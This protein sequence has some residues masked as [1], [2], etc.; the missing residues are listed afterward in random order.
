MNQILKLSCA[1]VLVLVA[2][3]CT[4]EGEADTTGTAGPGVGG[5]TTSANGGGS[6]GGGSTGGNSSGGGGAAPMP[7]LADTLAADHFSIARDDLCI[8]AVYDAPALEISGYGTTPTWGSHGGPLTFEADAASATIYRWNLSGS[9]LMATPEDVTLSGLPA[10]AYFGSQVVDPLGVPVFSWTG[11][12]F[13][14]E[15]GV[16]ADDLGTGVS[17]TTIGVTAMASSATSRFLFTALGPMGGTAGDAGVYAGKVL[18]T[19]REASIATDGEV[20]TWGLAT[21]AVAFDGAGNAFAIQTDYVTGTQELRAYASSDVEVGAPAIVG[22]TL[23]TIAG[24]GDALAAV[25]PAGADPGIVL[26]QPNDADT[27]AHLDVTSVEYVKTGAAI[28]VQGTPTPALTLTTADTNLTLM[29]DPSGRVWVG[30]SAT[31]G[32]STF[33]VLRRK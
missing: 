20:D 13:M 6:Q 19:P 2:F 33:Y 10:G 30:G 28:A 32:G 27:S 21:G 7:C 25:T 24:Y 9:T 1:S 18:L 17:T 23:A 22:V 29:T 12:S 11:A 14:T 15:G 3:G 8:V 5:G 26:F 16:I 4:D 31:G